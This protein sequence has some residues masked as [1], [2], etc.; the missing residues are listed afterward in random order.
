MDLHA[1][2]NACTRMIEFRII[3]K[4][5]LVQIEIPEAVMHQRFGVSA[6]AHGLLEAYEAHRELIDAAVI[7]LASASGPGVVVLRPMDLN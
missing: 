3:R 5:Q 2:V 7:R 1:F 6:A 4:G